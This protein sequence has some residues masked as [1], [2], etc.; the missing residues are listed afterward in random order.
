ME[1]PNAKVRDIDPITA[2]QLGHD[3][4]KLGPA[5]IEDDADAVVN[6]IV[7]DDTMEI[8]RASLNVRSRTGLRLAGVMFVMGVNQGTSLSILH[9]YAVV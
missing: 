5:H 7:E 8:S 9:V 1:S 3:D 6:R 2:Q 4:E